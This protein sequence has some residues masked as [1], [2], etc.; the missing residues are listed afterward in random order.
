MIIAIVLFFYLNTSVKTEKII[1]V[2]KGSI[3]SIVTHLSKEGYD[4]NRFD[5]MILR[6]MGSPQYGWINLGKEEL[7]KG[8]F[9]WLLTKAK[10]AT[11]SITLIPGDT[12][13]VALDKIAQAFSLDRQKLQ[14]AYDDKAPYADGVLVPDTYNL[15][16]GFNESEMMDY[17]LRFALSAHEKLAREY[18][19]GYDREKW[20][21]IVTIAS[22][23][24]KE[25]A[26]HEE[27]PLVSSVIYNR[28]AKNMRLQMDGSLNY[29]EY[30]NQ[31]V[32][33]RR[34]R[35][36]KSR[37]NTYKHRGLPPHPVSIVSIF[38]LKAA[39]SPTKSNYLYFVKNDSG[40]HTFS[41]S[42]KSHLKAIK[43]GKN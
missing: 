35:Q 40:T 9:L 14:D 16:I 17:L 18:Q 10:A 22:I 39:L 33:S 12:T 25:A 32:T 19:G 41:E 4:V 37:F 28:L 5:T 30:S 23:I 42:Y 3:K 11:R 20:F 27:M 43:N 26:N 13:Y 7:G 6:L 31:R 15:P 29:G 38:A 34:I 1:Y 36:D 21:R 2:P 24:E 8:E